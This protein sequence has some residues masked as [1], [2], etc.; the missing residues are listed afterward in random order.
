ML[1]ITAGEHRGRKLKVPR[2]SA[3]RPLTERAREG[4]MS[5]LQGIILDAVV[6]DLYAGSGILGL[7]AL[8]RGAAE[9]IALEWSHKAVAQLRENVASLGVEGKIQ[10]RRADVLT[11]PKTWKQDPRPDILFFDP[12][13][14]DFT[15]GGAQRERV[16]SV[17]CET[18]RRLNNHGCAVIHTPR[19]ELTADEV[20]ELPGLVQRDYSNASIWWWHPPS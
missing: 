14:A 12:P 16:W 3:T 11:F 18:A 20:A 5:H 1:R 4:V 8:S 2:V 7:E 9:V 6:W 19:G 17:F 15:Q 13:Y 10:V